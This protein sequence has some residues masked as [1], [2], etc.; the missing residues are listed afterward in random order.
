MARERDAPRT[1][2]SAHV[3]VVG[4]EVQRYIPKSLSQ[5]KPVREGALWRG[6][7]GTSGTTPHGVQIKPDAPKL[8]VGSVGD[9]FGN[10]FSESQERTGV[11]TSRLL[12]S[13]VRGLDGGMRSPGLSKEKG[14]SEAAKWKRND[15]ERNG[16]E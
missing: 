6:R 1:D 11:H 3:P 14:R 7:P 12:R 16:T 15:M 2:I 9:P 13:P 4:L 10:P 8:Y 5:P